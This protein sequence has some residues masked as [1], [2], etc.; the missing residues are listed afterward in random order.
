MAMMRVDFRDC[1]QANDGFGQL[2]INVKGTQL[3]TGKLRGRIDASFLDEVIFMSSFVDRRTL[4]TG[5]KMPGMTPLCFMAKGSESYY[6]GDTSE[7][8]ELCGFINRHTDTHVHWIGELCATY[9]PTK[10]LEAYLHEVG[11]FTA[12]ERMESINGLRLSP[13]NARALERMFRRGLA[14]DLVSSEQVY[15][16]VAM[17]LEEPVEEEPEAWD[18][19]QDLALRM[20]VQLAHENAMQ[21]P[22]SVPEIVVALGLDQ[23]QEKTLRRKCKDGYGMGIAQLVK[24]VRLEQARLSITK[25]GLNVSGAARRHHFVDQGKFS[26]D[27][28]KAYGL[29]PSEEFW[30]QQPRFEL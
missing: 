16:R 21:R 11:A 18:P 10:R 20:L 12:L 26:K 23:R 19:K 28:K 4:F 5:A 14:N 7:G 29:L 1:G 17:L 13:V 15:G 25:D 30:Y 24:R 3:E 2:K 6:H 8:G 9:V 22:L 27:Y